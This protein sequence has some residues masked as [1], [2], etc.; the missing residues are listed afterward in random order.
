M[1]EYLNRHLALYAQIASLM[2]FLYVLFHPITLPGCGFYFLIP[3]SYCL[4]TFY[5]KEIFVYHIGAYGLKCFFG[6]SFIKYTVLP[7]LVCYYEGNGFPINYSATGYHYAILISSIEILVSMIIIKIYYPKSMR[8]QSQFL[9]KKKSY[10]SDLS[11]GGLIFV[12]LLAFMVYKRGHMGEVMDGIRFLVVVSKFDQQADFWTYEIWSVQLMLAFFTIVVTS[13]FQKK[14]DR[15]PSW[16]NIIFP[17]IMVFISCTLILTNNRMTIVYYALSGLCILNYAFPKKEK[18]MSAIIIVSMIVVI[19]TFTL[20]KNYSIDISSDSSTSVSSNRA[21]ADLDEYM[22]GISSVAHT[23]ENYL[24]TGDKFDINNLIAE[25][26]RFAMPMRIPGLLP[27]AYANYP[28]TIDLATTGTEMVAVA[29]ETLFW[30]GVPFGWLLDIIVVYI[31]VRILIHYDIR[32]KLSRDLGKRYVYSWMAILFGM[33]MCYAVQ[34]LWNN[35]TYMPLY[36][37]F[38]L[39]INRQFS[40]RKKQIET[41]IHI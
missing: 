5:C 38:I 26:L 3:M 14:E 17:L 19:V 31:I 9:R 8:R 33:F 12:L 30:G 24:I 37:T 22:C 11:V 34:T 20:I 41:L 13:Y 10:Y 21:V 40:M 36:L 7:C 35:S 18:T 6:V 1:I 2:A 25:I 32:S 27:D 15:R 28:T 23:Y 4:M 39:W 16:K 29:G